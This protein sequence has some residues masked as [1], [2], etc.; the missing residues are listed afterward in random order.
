MKLEELVYQ[1]DNDYII[2]EEQLWEMA[3]VKPADSGLSWIIFVSSREYAKQRHWA[4][5][6]VSNIPGKF[7]NDDNFV[8]SIDKQPAVLEGTPRMSKS[9]LKDIFDWIKLNYDVLLKYW[10]EEFVSDAELYSKL[11]KL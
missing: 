7:A 9:E 11:R 3:R 10:N 4:R 1:P 8:V 6:K 5:V 2:S